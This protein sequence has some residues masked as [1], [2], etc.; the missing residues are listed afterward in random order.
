MWLDLP[1][2]VQ[3]YKGPKL[4]LLFTG[5]GA[6][7]SGLLGIPG[8]SSLVDSL[9]VP[10]S[11]ESVHGLLRDRHPDPESIIQNCGSVSQEMAVALH[12]CNS[13]NIGNCIPVSVTAAVST[14][15]YRK[16]D[17]HAFIVVGPPSSFSTYHLALHKLS[18]E[19]HTPEAVAAKRY[20]ED[21]MIGEVALALSL[22][23]ESQLVNILKEDGHLVNLS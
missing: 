17:N 10:Y 6:W 15:R 19:E 18:E 2:V 1:S 3:T 22:D 9:Y 23:V 5:A 16:G 8:A 7:A 21:R 20:I 11:H 4:R 13:H 12:L 14:N